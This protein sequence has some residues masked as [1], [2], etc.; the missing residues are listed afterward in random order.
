[1][2]SR[3]HFKK[4][5]KG[6]R[7]V[8]DRKIARNLLKMRTRNNNIRE[9]WFNMQIRKYGPQKYMAILKASSK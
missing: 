2:K 7:P 1:M 4:P 8:M 5:E 9:A 3:K 6:G